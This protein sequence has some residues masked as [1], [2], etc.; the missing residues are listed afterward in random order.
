M[1]NK[2]S[3][4][5]ILSIV[6]NKIKEQYDEYKFHIS[7]ASNIINVAGILIGILISFYKYIPIKSM[8]CFALGLFLFVI[9]VIISICIFYPSKLIK[10]FKPSYLAENFM[11][12]SPEETKEYLISAYL[13]SYRV[14]DIV[15]KRKNKMVIISVVTLVLGLILLILSV[16]VN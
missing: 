9:T 8:F 7:K 6:K 10:G 2:P 15:I 3:L 4:D 5:I 1:S 14:N 11:F 16:L 13:E 12:C